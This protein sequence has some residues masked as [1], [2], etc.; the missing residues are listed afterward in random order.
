MGLSTP[1]GQ[2]R[3]KVQ[4]DSEEVSVNLCYG[5]IN[6]SER[7]KRGREQEGREGAVSPLSL[8]PWLAG[9]GHISDPHS[10]SGTMHSCTQWQC[11]LQEI[12]PKLKGSRPL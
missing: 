8:H 4:M 12:G 2:K 6:G 7:G 11:W 10:G 3:L 5:A 1:K 9:M